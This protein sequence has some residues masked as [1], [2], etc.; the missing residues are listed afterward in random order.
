MN[1][2][3]GIITTLS[4][5]AITRVGSGN[6]IIATLPSFQESLFF[7]SVSVESSRSVFDFISVVVSRRRRG[8]SLDV[9]H[10]QAVSHLFI[11]LR[12]PVDF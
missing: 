3:I 1:K 5:L 6:T 4:T 8:P 2:F 12:R 9:A 11:L 10:V 7:K